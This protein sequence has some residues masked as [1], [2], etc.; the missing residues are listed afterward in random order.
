MAGLGLSVV[1]GIVAGHRGRHECDTQPA[2]GS[3]FRVHLP[4]LEHEALDER[5]GRSAPRGG[6]DLV[7]IVD[8]D[9]TL[10]DTLHETLEQHGYGT[11]EA[12]DG[13]E[14][15]AI[16]SARR[17]DIEAVLLDMTMPRMGGRETFG[18]RRAI[19]PEVRILLSTGSTRD[20]DGQALLDSGS[21]VFIHTP[22]DADALLEAVR[23][24]LA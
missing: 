17:V 18:R 2:A 19:D 23:R 5:R 20:G 16:L 14:A 13:E 11:C 24:V 6:H 3:V 1:Y 4:V 7:L 8:D 21:A 12:S 9:Q 15:V 22:F 10:R